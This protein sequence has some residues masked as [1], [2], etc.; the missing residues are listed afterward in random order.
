[1]V[2]CY[3]I[4]FIWCCRYSLP[5]MWLPTMYSII[6]PHNCHDAYPLNVLHPH[7][8]YQ[9]VL[10]QDDIYGLKASYWSKYRLWFT[11]G[12]IILSSYV[13]LLCGLIIYNSQIRHTTVYCL[14]HFRFLEFQKIRYD[15]FRIIK[16]NF[17]LNM[18]MFE[19][20]RTIFKKGC[21][22]CTKI[23]NHIRSL[24]QSLIFH[25]HTVLDKSLSG[26][27]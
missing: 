6:N 25:F 26:C 11:M 8:N 27:L 24:R 3:V 17:N 16:L 9:Y 5:R 14:S 13:K 12:I 18:M 10:S 2:L 15:D 23:Q 4:E 22:V 7:N 20:R 19:S 21:T 1:M